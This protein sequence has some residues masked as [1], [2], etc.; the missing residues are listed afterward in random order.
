[1]IKQTCSM[2][3]KY[4]PA[5]EN[6]WR[7]RRVGEN[8]H[9]Y[10]MRVVEKG[11]GDLFRFAQ[12][13]DAAL[14]SR[15]AQGLALLREAL[16]DEH[17]SQL[18]R[19]LHDQ[20]GVVAPPPPCRIGD[21]QY[22]AIRCQRCSLV[23]VVCGA[24]SA[25]NTLADSLCDVCNCIDVENMEWAAHMPCKELQKKKKKKKKKKRARSSLRE[26]ATPS[27]TELVEMLRDSKRLCSGPSVSDN[28][29][30]PF[31]WEDSEAIHT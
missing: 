5:T 8:F 18:D 28:N 4:I 30:T 11:D 23:S 24:H 16:D 25:E 17:T 20:E 29:Q 9:D 27:T 10:R 26:A 12:I 19:Y 6:T 22:S 14:K 13:M 2:F 21:V 1:M 3:N 7:P 31:Q 15:S